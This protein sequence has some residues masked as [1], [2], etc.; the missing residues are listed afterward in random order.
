[1]ILSSS[2]CSRRR[3]ANL[4]FISPSICLCS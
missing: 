1:M 2:I 3:K 4:Y